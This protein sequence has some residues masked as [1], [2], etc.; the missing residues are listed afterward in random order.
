VTTKFFAC[1]R[2]VKNNKCDIVN[3]CTK[4]TSAR[5]YEIYIIRPDGS[6]R[7]VTT[8]PE[9]YTPDLP[10]RSFPTWVREPHWS[11][12]GTQ[13]VY[14]ATVNGTSNIHIIRADGKHNRRLT[15]CALRKGAADLS[16]YESP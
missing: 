2:Q 7:Q 9:S 12:D 14:A 13:I 3:V 16:A 1:R 11:P 5:D 6:F 8:L 10:M 4:G 15:D